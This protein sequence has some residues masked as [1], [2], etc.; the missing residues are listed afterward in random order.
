MTRG[1]EVICCFW[2]TMWPCVYLQ[3]NLSP[4]IKH[5]DKTKIKQISARMRDKCIL[6][7]KTLIIPHSC[8]SLSSQMNVTFILIIKSRFSVISNITDFLKPVIKLLFHSGG[9][10]P[11]GFLF[12]AF[13]STGVSSLVS[14]WWSKFSSVFFL[15]SLSALCGLRLSLSRTL[16]QARLSFYPILFMRLP[17][18]THIPS[19]NDSPSTVSTPESNKKA[20]QA[21]IALPSE[22]Q[23]DTGGW[24]RNKLKFWGFL[25]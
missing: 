13:R 10:T 21:G 17:Q 23:A 25:L 6:P 22:C 19:L 24:R 1:K 20:R 2:Y 18:H 14:C 12:Q 15:F 4:S 8:W 11:S 16:T 3:M 9:W 5:L 7:V